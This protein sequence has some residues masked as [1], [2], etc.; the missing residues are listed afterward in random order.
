MAARFETSDLRGF[1]LS[2]D[3]KVPNAALNGSRLPK[4]SKKMRKT[5]SFSVPRAL[6]TAQATA[7]GAKL[8]QERVAVEIQVEGSPADFCPFP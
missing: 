6:A 4:T 7:D 2:R 5:L 1:V 8:C 3:E